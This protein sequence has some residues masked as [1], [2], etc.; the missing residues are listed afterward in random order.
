MLCLALFSND[1]LLDVISCAIFPEQITGCHTVSCAIFPGQTTG[2]HILRYFPR[3]TTGC[4]ILRHFPR[5][6][7]GCHM[8]RFLPILPGQATGYWMSY[9]ALFSKD[10][11]LGAISCAIFPGQTSEC[12]I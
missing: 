12:R 9:L 5:K 6:N 1:E 7:T 10:K 3:Q 11:L 4:R 8:L 2:Y